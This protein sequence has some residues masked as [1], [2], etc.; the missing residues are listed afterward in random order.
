MV[1]YINF[2]ERHDGWWVS[3][4]AADARTVLTGHRR[5]ASKETLLKLLAYYGARSW[6]ARNATSGNGRAAPH[7]V[8][9]SRESK[10]CCG[11]AKPS[12]HPALGM[13][14]PGPVRAALEP[15]E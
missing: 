12:T 10:T 2:Q 1:I 6:K 4:L 3:A 11:S 14:S 8:S 15:N 13:R 7:G 5:V 9:R